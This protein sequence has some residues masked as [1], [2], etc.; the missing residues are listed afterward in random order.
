MALLDEPSAEEACQAMGK[1]F[2]ADGSLCQ[3]DY[4]KQRQRVRGASGLMRK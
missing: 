4:D 1:L 2:E 3:N